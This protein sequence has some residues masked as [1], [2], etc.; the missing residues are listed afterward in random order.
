MFTVVES[1]LTSNDTAYSGDQDYI[2]DKWGCCGT[3]PTNIGLDC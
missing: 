1:E 2:N 3:D